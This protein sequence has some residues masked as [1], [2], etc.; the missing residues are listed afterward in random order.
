MTRHNTLRLITGSLLLLAVA[1]GDKEAAPA[2]GGHE[3]EGHEH[4]GHEHME[5]NKGGDPFASLGAEDAKL[6]KAQGVCPVSDEKLGSM[7]AP[8]KVMVKEKPVFICC[9]SCKKMLEREPERYLAK[10][11]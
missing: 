3:H 11:K 5:E 4:E 2:S 1:C 8:I 10:L 7:G 9:P 6:A